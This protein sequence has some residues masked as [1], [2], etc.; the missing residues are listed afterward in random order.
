MT[1]M[2]PGEALGL[3]LGDLQKDRVIIKR[4]V[5]SRNQITEGKNENARRV[6]PIDGLASSI[7]RKTIE[8]NERHNLHTDWIFC[9]PDGSMGNQSTMRN[10]WQAL[11]EER[12]LPGTV[13]S[14]RHTF[15][16]M[17]KNVMPEQM[18]KD[19]CGHSISFDSFGTYGHIYES[20]ARE[21]ASII[22][23]TFGADFGADES[24]T[25]GNKVE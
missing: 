13:Y 14:L 2:R 20:E 7:L 15:I 3:R 24:V 25:G 21:A 5:N 18:I 9:S 22:S 8:R 11:K 16:T 1:G 6:I 10:H 19:I 17:M 12:D 23:L 4:A